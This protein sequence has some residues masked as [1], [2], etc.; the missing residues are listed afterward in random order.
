MK[1]KY[2]YEDSLTFHENLLHELDE[3][4]DYWQETLLTDKDTEWVQS[5]IDSVKISI[6]RNYYDL[7]QLKNT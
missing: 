3:W 6:R 2:W 7:E 1:N 5:K 4:L